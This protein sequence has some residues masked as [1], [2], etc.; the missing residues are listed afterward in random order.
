MIEPLPEWLQLRQ[1]Q[2]VGQLREQKPTATFPTMK[3]KNLLD[4][5]TKRVRFLALTAVLLQIEC[6]AMLTLRRLVNG[7]DKR[8]DCNLCKT[9]LRSLNFTSDM[10]ITNGIDPTR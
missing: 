7:V 5:E 6:S 3:I 9:S 8:T 4:S 1:F 2:L 10:G